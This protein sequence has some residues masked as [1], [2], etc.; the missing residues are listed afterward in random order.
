MSIQ[1]THPGVYPSYL[2]DIL[3]SVI[4]IAASILADVVDHL[5]NF[6]KLNTLYSAGSAVFSDSAAAA[7][8]VVAVLLLVPIVPL[9]SL[10][11]LALGS[12][13]RMNIHLSFEQAAHSEASLM[14]FLS[15]V[16]SRF[17]FTD[18]IL[19][20]CFVLFLFVPA[21]S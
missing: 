20:V 5:D 8:A 10:D 2:L 14:S 13:S 4:V 6:G 16:R 18:V 19:S 11:C 9:S 7:A 15:G 12:V 21:E 3:S 1:R 17:C